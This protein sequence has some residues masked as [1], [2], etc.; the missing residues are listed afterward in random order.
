MKMRAFFSAFLLLPTVLSLFFIKPAAG[1]PVPGKRLVADAPR[2]SAPK[3]IG[4]FGDWIAAT[5]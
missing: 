1:Q 4:R 3:A 5:R 2:S